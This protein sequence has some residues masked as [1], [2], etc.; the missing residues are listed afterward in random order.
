MA[1]T[2][3]GEKILSSPRYSTWTMGEPS[4][5]MTLNGHDSISFLT[6][7]SSKRRPINRL[8]YVSMPLAVSKEAAS[9]LDIEDGVSGVHRSLVLSRLTDQTLLVGEGDERWC[10]EATLLVGNDLNIGSLIVGH[11]F[12]SV[13]CP[14]ARRR[15]F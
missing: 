14:L 8:G 15:L 13:H 9:S 5:S 1:E 12:I 11:Y 10:S 2:S 4:W 3:C 7:G 6:V